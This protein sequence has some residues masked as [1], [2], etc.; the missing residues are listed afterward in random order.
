MAKSMVVEES[1]ALPN[2]IRYA[3]VFPFEMKHRTAHR[4]MEV[5]IK[6]LP[7]YKRKIINISEALIE[8]P[9][10]K[11]GEKVT[12]PRPKKIELPEEIRDELNP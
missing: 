1:S 7:E 4:E 2:E 12:Y 11:S 3:E 8:E 5:P 10:A 9:V 6:R